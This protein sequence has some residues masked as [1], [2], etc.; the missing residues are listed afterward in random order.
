MKSIVTVLWQ[1]ILPIF[2]IAGF[3]FALQRW[4]TIDKRTLSKVTLY[5]LSPS[6]V[7]SSLVNS[8]LPGEE[9]IDLAVFTVV[10]ILVM[11]MLAVLVA[12]ALRLPRRKLV[13]LLVVTIFVNSGNYGLTL[14][15]LRYG[16]AGLSRAIVYY[17]TST[18]LLYSV[19]IFLASMGRLHWRQA[20]GRMLRLPPVYAAAGAIVVYA[21]NLPIPTPLLRAVEVAGQGAIPVMLLVLGMQIGSMQGGLEWRLTAPAVILRLLV[22]PVVAVMVAGFLGITGLGRATS[23]IEASMPTAVITI[24]L[25]TEFDLQPSAVTSIVILTTLLSPLTLAATITLLGL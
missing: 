2:V 19:G 21:F 16:E 6:L 20:L 1:N 3:G 17:T 5:V 9:L 24:I 23:V 13:T 4:Q 7:F 12:T 14:V 10:V 18:I 22:A 25:A 8:R 15:Q 11:A